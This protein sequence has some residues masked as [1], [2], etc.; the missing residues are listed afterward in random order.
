MSFRLFLEIAMRADLEM[1]D[2]V[3]YVDLMLNR[4]SKKLT[5]TGQYNWMH[6]NYEY[7]SDH[8]DELIQLT[9][10]YIEKKIPNFRNMDGNRRDIMVMTFI[11]DRFQQDYGKGS[12]RHIAQAIKSGLTDPEALSNPELL[13]PYMRSKGGLGVK[14]SGKENRA[15]FEKR[16]RAFQ[17]FL[18]QKF[19]E[20]EQPKEI[21]VTPTTTPADLHYA[22]LKRLRSMDPSQLTPSQ[23]G[24]LG[25]RSEGFGDQGLMAS[26]DDGGDGAL[27]RPGGT[28]SPPTE[29]GSKLSKKID[30]LY[31]KKPTGVVVSKKKSYSPDLPVMGGKSPPIL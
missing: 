30:N 26:T 25:V 6:N 21:P 9:K 20:P 13:K 1:P 5:R 15:N 11:K 17:D 2:P 18:Q 19:M 16:A 31:G 8:R 14:R 7:W 10:D 23:R 28:L 3:Y 24:Y 12:R 4:A 29:S 22:Y 27:Y